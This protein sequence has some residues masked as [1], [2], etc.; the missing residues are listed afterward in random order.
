[1]HSRWWEGG[2]AF[3]EAVCTIGSDEQAGDQQNTNQ[4]WHLVGY[5]FHLNN[6]LL[7]GGEEQ[8]TEAEAAVNRI[9]LV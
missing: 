8:Q 7:F 4:N 3:Y 6:S 2:P 1:M 5:S 9:T